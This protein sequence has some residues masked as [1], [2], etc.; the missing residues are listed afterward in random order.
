MLGLPMREPAKKKDKRSAKATG[1]GGQPSA[2]P[3]SAGS[4]AALSARAPRLVGWRKW[5]LIGSGSKS[6]FTGR[7]PV[8]TVSVR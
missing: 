2:A 7:I 6:K 4:P 5:L 3:A 8:V 1:R